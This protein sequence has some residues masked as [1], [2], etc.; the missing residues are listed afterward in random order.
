MD[1]SALNA[2]VTCR[3]FAL[4]DNEMA[5][6]CQNLNPTSAPVGSPRLPLSGYHLRCSPHKDAPF[7]TIRFGR[8]NSGDRDSIEATRFDQ[9]DTSL[10]NGA[11]PII[12]LVGS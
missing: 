8:D 2:I 1:R 3:K 10:T 4:S 7:G 6:E 11:C 5:P 12:T 9:G